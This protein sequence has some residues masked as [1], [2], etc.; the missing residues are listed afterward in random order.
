M[1]W[2]EACDNPH[3]ITSRYT[4]VPD[5]T[6][7]PLLNTISILGCP[8]LA[9]TDS[10]MNFQALRVCA[11]ASFLRRPNSNLFFWI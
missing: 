3:T 7:F 6:R 10:L 4:D 9:F 11:Q 5:L 1:Q 8:S 2:Y